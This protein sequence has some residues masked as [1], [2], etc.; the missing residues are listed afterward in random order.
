MDLATTPTTHRAEATEGIDL[1]RGVRASSRDP[2][3]LR[4]HP[5]YFSSRAFKSSISR[6][7]PEI[8]IIMA[9]INQS[10]THQTAPIHGSDPKSTVPTHQTAPIHPNPH[11]APSQKPHPIPH[12][13]PPIKQQPQPKP[14]PSDDMSDDQN[15]ALRIHND[16]NFYFFLPFRYNS[17]LRQVLSWLSV[18]FCP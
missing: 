12:P 1:N 6:Y 4:F 3:Q 15:N 13:V 8:Y 5:L 7:S 14:A 2:I 10:S 11:Q 18:I 17:L 9:I 16:G